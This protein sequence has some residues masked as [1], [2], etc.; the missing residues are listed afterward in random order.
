MGAMILLLYEL[1][2]VNPLGLSTLCPPVS[3]RD[4]SIC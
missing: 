1:L 2:Y 3:G 4:S